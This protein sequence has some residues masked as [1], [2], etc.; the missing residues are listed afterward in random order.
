MW[1]VREAWPLCVAFG[2]LTWTLALGSFFFL[3]REGNVV[4]I[5]GSECF[6][7]VAWGEAVSG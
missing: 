6:Q 7:W 2:L 5:A 3:P 4:Q 1:R